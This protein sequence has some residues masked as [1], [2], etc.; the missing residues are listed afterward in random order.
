M[1]R[2]VTASLA[3][4]LALFAFSAAS[5]GPESK[6]ADKTCA[7]GEGTAV[8][9]THFKK[10]CGSHVACSEVGNA[11][12]FGS[13]ARTLTAVKSGGASCCATSAAKGA[14][15]H[16]ASAT[17]SAKSA[18]SSAACCAGTENRDLGN[19]RFFTATKDHAACCASHATDSAAA[20]CCAG[21]ASAKTAAK[22]K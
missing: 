3:A 18:G 17:K 2:F 4:G 8:C 16:G 21:K 5:A 19:V 12:F 15:T 10:D 22:T 7:R 13:G 11:A 6:L 9:A 1:Y 14:K 20:A